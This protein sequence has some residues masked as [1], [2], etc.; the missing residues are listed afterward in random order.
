MR[1]P[2]RRH[3]QASL[4]MYELVFSTYPTA[5][6]EKRSLPAGE[7]HIFHPWPSSLNYKKDEIKDLCDY[8][9]YLQP[10]YLVLDVT[11]TKSS[12]MRGE[13]KKNARH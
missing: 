12:F 13:G 5:N 6:K 7:A 9:C 11:H 3:Q 10:N 1:P 4:F 8:K 2:D